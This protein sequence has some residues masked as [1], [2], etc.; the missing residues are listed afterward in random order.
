MGYI[1]G[2]SFENDRIGRYFKKY[3]GRFLFVE[4]SEEFMKKLNIEDIAKGVRVPIRPEDLKEFAGGEG[5]SATKIAEN[6]VWV[7]GC[8]PNFTYAEKYKEYM[9]RFFNKQLAMDVLMKGV[10]AIN[11]KEMEI[12]CIH[13]RA[14]LFLRPDMMEAMYNYA[15]V[16]R[17]IY[18]ESDDEESIGWFKAECLDTFEQ[19]TLDFPDFD[20][21]YYFLGYLYL[22]LGLYTKAGVTFEKFMTI[23]KDP[24]A[25]QE[26]SQRLRQIAEPRK[27]E[28]GC[29]LIISGKYQEGLNILIGYTASD[30]E[31]WWPLHLYL[32]TAYE[33]LGNDT[34]AESEYKRTLQLNAGNLESM[35]GLIRIY[36]RRDDL[37]N[38]KKYTQKK[39]LVIEN[40]KLDAEDN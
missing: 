10:Q 4:F 14:A 7:V 2:I 20:Q 39:E 34:M 9:A 36:E 22:N 38:Y 24:Q 6:M 12:A 13:F 17:E 40:F 8:D 19:L 5:V 31:T 35:D 11:M 1:M 26:V 29:N 3:L 21:P 25:V 18:M 16:C 15:R 27:I 30:Y 37:E 23:A 32:G 28:E 33:E